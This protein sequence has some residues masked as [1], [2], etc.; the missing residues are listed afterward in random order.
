MER[1]L[2]QYERI[3]G[4]PPKKVNIPMA[5]DASPELDSSEL[6]PPDQVSL[7]QSLI[8]ALQWCVTLGRFDI[9]VGVM[10]LSSF[11][12]APTLGHLELVKE[13]LVT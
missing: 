9:L 3:F 6:L 10:S 1:I 8:G 4:G 7:Y 5:Q 12:I 2:N 11:R 13:C